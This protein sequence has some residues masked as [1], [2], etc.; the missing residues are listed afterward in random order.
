MILE[1]LS[2]RNQ[3]LEQSVFTLS[4]D[5]NAIKNSEKALSKEL[6]QKGAVCKELLKENGDLRE[7]MLKLGSELNSIR[8]SNGV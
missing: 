2:I 1:S 7:E 6:E 8:R 4:K 5:L 3:E